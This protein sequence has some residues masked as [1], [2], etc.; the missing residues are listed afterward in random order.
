MSTETILNLGSDQM[1]NQFVVLFPEGI[2]GG[3][4]KDIIS[5]RMDQSFT[6]PDISYSTY[7]VNYRGLKILKP[8]LMEET[9]KEFTCEIRLDQQW[10][11][12]DALNTWMK[13]VFDPETHIAMDDALIRTS[14]IV[15][16]FGRNNDVAQTLTFKGVIIKSL[17]IGDFSPESGDPIRLSVGFTFYNMTT[18]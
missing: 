8:S 10:D 16:A 4:N 14:V 7:E 13:L 15:Q 17:K 11:V 18:A 5:L 2:P 1:S 6:P 9:S 12:Y 3:G